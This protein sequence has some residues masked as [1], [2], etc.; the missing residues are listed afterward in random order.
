MSRYIVVGVNYTSMSRYIVVGVN[1]TSVSRYIVV[2]VNYTSVSWYLGVTNTHMHVSKRF[3]S[4][5]CF[6]TSLESYS[7]ILLTLIN[8]YATNLCRG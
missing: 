1:Y 5:V 4:F 7:V 8:M 2:G 3:W 6:P